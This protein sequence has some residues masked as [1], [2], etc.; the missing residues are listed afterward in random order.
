M[1]DFSPP[2]SLLVG[3]GGPDPGGVGEGPL[4]YVGILGGVVDGSEPEA[5]FIKKIDD[6]IEFSIVFLVL[7]GAKTTPLKTPL[8]SQ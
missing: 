1:Q 7:C 6:S 3:V 4:Q 2:D 5:Q 8:E